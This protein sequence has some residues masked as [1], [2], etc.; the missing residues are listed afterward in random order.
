MTNFEWFC[1]GLM[2]LAVLGTLVICAPLGRIDLTKQD[3][4]EREA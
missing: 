4:P 3:D 2:L 1:A